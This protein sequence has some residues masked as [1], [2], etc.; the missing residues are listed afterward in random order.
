MIM[1]RLTEQ[2]IKPIFDGM[3]IYDTVFEKQTGCTM[4]ELAMQAS[5]FGGE[6]WKVKTAVCSIT[7]G[8]GIISGFAQAIACILKYYGIPG[9]VTGKTDVSGLLEAR[10]KKN[11][12]L[13]EAD[14]DTYLAMD[15]SNGVCSENGEATGRV[16]AEALRA[17]AEKNGRMQEMHSGPVLV[18]GA[19]PVGRA[20]AGYLVQKGFLVDLYD[21]IPQKAASFA[22][23]NPNVR[24]LE[25][26]PQYSRYSFLLDATPQREF[27]DA[28]SIS[29]GTIISA[30]GV[31]LGVTEAASQKALVIHNPLELGTL[32]MY[33]EC[34]AYGAGKDMEDENG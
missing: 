17:A 4:A 15:L 8:L 9:E 26:K 16:F 22:G 2:D 20:A 21:S 7:A 1:S 3:K 28:D 27:I 14:D 10:Q 29:P 24:A 13:F 33:F 34:L 32:M 25:Q 12:I 31:P 5:G 11:R 30:P 19:G 18:L 6:D 23:E